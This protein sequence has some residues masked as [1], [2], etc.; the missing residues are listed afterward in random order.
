MMEKIVCSAI[1]YKKGDKLQ[2]TCINVDEGIVLF[3]L[4]H[5]MWDLLVRLYPDYKQDHCTVQGFLTSEN[6]FV[7]RNEAAEIAF[8]SGQTEENKK[9][10]YSEDLY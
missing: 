7:E 1:W 10:L 6:R 4:R 9:F 5:T 8:K 3:G 2:H